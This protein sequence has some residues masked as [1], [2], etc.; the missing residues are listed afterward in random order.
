MARRDNYNSRN[1]KTLIDIPTILLD[2]QKCAWLIL[3]ISI[4]LSLLSY[5]YIRETYVPVF[6]IRTTYVITSRGYNNDLLSNMNT[7]QKMAGRFSEIIGS[8]VLKDKIVEDV[9]IPKSKINVR[10]DIV[11][12][13]NLM[14]LEVTAETPEEAFLVLKS[15]IKNYPYIA[16]NLISDAVINPL[17]MPTVPSYQ[18]N[19]INP[20]STMIK[21]CIVSMGG[22]ILLFSV[23]SCL[24]DTIRSGNDVQYKLNVDYLGE[25]FHENRNGFRKGKLRSGE[26]LLITKNTVSFRYIESVRIASR[27]IQNKMNREGHKS[28]LITSTFEDEGK[29]TIVANLAIALAELDKKVL[30]VDFDFRRPTQYKIFNINMDNSNLLGSALEGKVNCNE[31][32]TE[33]SIGGVFGIFNQKRI[34]ESSELLASEKLKFFFDSLAQSYDY[35]IVDTSPMAFVSDTEAI[36]NIVDA[37]VVVVREHLSSA[38]SINSILD[39][40][41]GCHSRLLGCL[42]NDSRGTSGL[43]MGGRGFNQYYGYGYRYYSDYYENNS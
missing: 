25:I 33:S 3:S 1:R 9:G 12:Q 4:S 42:V 29:S 10:A 27:K 31:I 20:K 24:R 28:L 22:L 21:V 8:S 11:E 19:P 43:G 7:A 13:T 34:R 30:I 6:R 5:I 39:T 41:D 40:L 26:A 2:L 17:V 35:I 36:A 16:D 18:I 14:T 23:I 32:V 38:R 37:S 15:A